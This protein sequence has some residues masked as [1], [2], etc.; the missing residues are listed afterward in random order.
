MKQTSFQKNHRPI[1]RVENKCSGLTVDG[2]CGTCGRPLLKNGKHNPSKIG[3]LGFMEYYS[4][5]SVRNTSE[6]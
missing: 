3:A 5:G 6:V 1:K 2:V 4:N